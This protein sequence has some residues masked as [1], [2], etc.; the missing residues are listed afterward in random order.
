MGLPALQTE[1]EAEREGAFQAFVDGLPCGVAWLDEHGTVRRT[2]QAA[3]E[4]LS[5]TSASRVH[6]VMIATLEQVRQTGACVC[7][8]VDLSN[9]ERLTLTLAPERTQGLF[10]V[11]FDRRRLERARAEAAVLQSVIRAMARASSKRESVASALAVVRAQL[12]RS[13]QMACFEVDGAH[14]R[15]QAAIGLAPS[16]LDRIVVLGGANCL[17]TAAWSNQALVHIPD[18]A[19]SSGQP[20]FEMGSNTAFLALPTGWRG[21][22][23]LLCV[24]GPREGFGEGTFR[25]LQGLADAIGAVTDVAA[26]EASAARALEVA[27]QRDRLATIGQLVAGVAHEINNPLAFLK[28]NLHSLKSEIADL[29]GVDDGAPKGELEAIVK[30]SLEGVSRI[31]TLVQALKGTARRRDERIRFDPSRA[32]AEAIT[33][34]KGAKKSECEIGSTMTQLPEVMG[35]PSALGQVILNLMQNGL[36]AMSGTERQRRR[37]EVIASSS[38]PHIEV[39][40]RDRGTGIPQAVQTHMWDAFFTTKDVGKGTGLGL[41]ICKDIIEEMGGSI[42]FET[43]SE[44]TTFRIQ[45]PAALEDDARS[46]G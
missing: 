23:G 16:D 37:L 15:C 36:D 21:R 42:D 40:V 1:V 20:P 35:S 39:R 33:I 28:S 10:V 32:I 44:G 27:T 46:G 12:P 2:N 7:A 38:G 9:A 13:A 22:R 3:S 31:E 18:V 43:S 8:H 6:A 30:E 5:G 24:S 41:A 14:A 19:C 45:I 29:Q 25:M 4:L 26:V 17:L 11:S 34:F